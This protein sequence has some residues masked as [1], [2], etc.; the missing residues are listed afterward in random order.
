M[1]MCILRLTYR[2]FPGGGG[3][4]CEILFSSSRL[5]LDLFTAGC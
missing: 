2:S 1:H 3:N 5:K 4:P